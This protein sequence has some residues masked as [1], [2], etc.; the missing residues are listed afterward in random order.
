MA[1]DPDTTETTDSNRPT[2]TSAPSDYFRIFTYATRWDLCV[3][4]IAVVAS[5]GAGVTM[6]LMNVIFGQ[7]VGQFTDYTK[8]ESTGNDFNQ[9]LDR[10]ALYIMALFIVRWALISINKFCFRMIGIRLSSAIRQNYLQALFSQPI[11]VIDSMAPGAPAT[12]ITTTSNTLQLGI[13]ERLGTCLQSLVTILTALV[14]A[15]TWSWDLTLVTLSLIIYIILATSITLPLIVKGQTA[16]SEAD[17]EATSIASEA[18]AGIR[19]VMAC[20]AQNYIISQYTKWVVDS[21]KKGQKMG[22]ILGLQV[23]LVVGYHAISCS[24]SFR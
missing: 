11:H 9:V 16:V 4:A 19:L 14:I 1:D 8:V 12:A 10:Q 15:F 2:R 6:P 24:F 5:I 3:Y 20:S 17:A 7:L 21:K 13:S 18:L 23:G 22:M